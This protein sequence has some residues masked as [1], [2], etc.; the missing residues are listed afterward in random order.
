MHSNN[1]IDP[2]HVQSFKSYRNS[3]A[4]VSRLP[5]DLLTDIFIL[6]HRT[7]TDPENTYDI[8]S[9]HSP[10]LLSPA[11]LHISHVSR[12]WRNAALRC[13]LLWTNILFIP[14]EWTA[15]MLE[16]SQTAPLTVVIPIEDAIL[17][18]D[19]FKNSVRLALS[20]IRQIRYLS[21]LLYNV[22]DLGDLLSP[23][24]SGPFDILEGLNLSGRPFVLNHIYPSI[25]KALYLR[26]LVLQHCS[27]NWQLF[28]VV[29]NLTSLVLDITPLAPKPSVD[30]MLSIL[31]TMSKLER[32]ILIHAI[33]E[34]PRVIRTL[35]PLTAAV[36]VKLE[37]LSYLSLRGF[38]PD[39]A[40]LMRYLDMPRCRQVKLKA[41]AIRRK[42][43]V[44]LAVP[45]LANFISSMFCRLD[46]RERLY[47]ASI[48]GG[49]DVFHSSGIAITVV[50]P[51]VDAE[52]THLDLYL[53]WPRSHQ[54]GD[55]EASHRFG[56]L[57]LC[58]PLGQI[59]YFR[60]STYSREEHLTDAEWLEVLVRLTRVE[61][62]L[63]LG[64]YTY[65][66]VN[67]FHDAHFLDSPSGSDMMVLPKLRS[68]EIRN[69]HFSFPL[70][71]NELFSTL[72]RA[73]T[74]RRERG[75]T[76]PK[77]TLIDCHV[78][79]QQLAVL[80]TLASE[81]VDC[82]GEPETWGV[83]ESSGGLSDED[84]LMEDDDD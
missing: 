53:V 38:A 32:L 84:I 64:G 7:V 45:A 39:C 50:R 41:G 83:G 40:N 79:A 14:P 11:C 57:L 13:P 19:A 28:P 27:I 25:E 29:G 26:S 2:D 62:V 67:A 54:L 10:S 36:P 48:N 78:T 43:D 81:P 49:G 35:P 24:P 82:T 22:V 23:F 44:I 73:L 74:R 17:T 20:R 34:L 21:I 16:R 71:D 31:R 66:V 58:L 65:G 4:P 5:Y 51:V 30:N 15:I 8:F 52:E 1:D 42:Q 61:T 68:L 47:F 33:P 77:I 55:V 3:L 18:S 12:A 9:L 60:V 70:G 69:A 46:E 75:W 56:I 37:H 72:K 63:L 76:I 59:V 80:D 6:L